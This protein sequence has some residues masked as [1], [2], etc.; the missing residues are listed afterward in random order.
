M[1]ILKRLKKHIP[2]AGVLAGLGALYATGVIAEPSCL[3]YLMQVPSLLILS[4]TA[5]ARVNDIGPER[6]GWIW[7]WRRVGLSLVGVA[8]VSLLAAPFV[9]DYNW[10]TW[11]GLMLSWGFALSWISTPGMPPWWKYVSGEAKLPKGMT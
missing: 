3:T 1:G 7:Q 11:K 9:G 10:P 2:L 5:L 4:F 8:S 6:T